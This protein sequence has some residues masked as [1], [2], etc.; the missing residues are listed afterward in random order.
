MLHSLWPKTGR[1]LF[2]LLYPPLFIYLRLNARTRV[3]IEH[4]GKILL[5]KPWLGNGSWDLPGGGLHIGENPKTGALREVLEE[6]GIGLKASQ[7]E[8]HG[9][10][11]A[12]GLYGFRAH[13]FYVFLSKEPP[14]VRQQVELID[15]RWVPKQ[16]L[17]TFKLHPFTRSIL[18]AQALASQ[19]VVK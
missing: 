3:V 14:I 1:A 15:I 13:V 12:K 7:L 4:E 18:D 19:S 10:L 11:R 6:T 5:V 8:S 17:T 16:Q 9:T 2:W